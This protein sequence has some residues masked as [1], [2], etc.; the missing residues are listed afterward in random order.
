MT[1]FVNADNGDE[2][3]LVTFDKMSSTAHTW[4]EM[5]DPV[6]GGRSTGTT[7]VTNGMLIFDGEV[8]IV[9]SLQAP[10]FIT[11]TTRD[12]K[13]F[14]DV[15]ACQGVALTLKSEMPY[16]GYRFSFGSAHAPG[17]KFFAYGYKCHIDVPVGD[18]GTVQIPF[19][20]FTDYWD[21]A[22]GNPI[23]TCEEGKIYCPDESTLRNMKTMQ[24][25]GEGIAGKVHLEV[26]AISAYGCTTN[27]TTEPSFIVA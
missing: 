16:K 2:I 10:G 22:T 13:R 25:W 15:S 4:R 18:F 20:N 27:S 26:K 12:G 24:F 5:N 23:K 8:A 19:S 21:D 17:G 7:T 3:A 9:P 14:P 1:R 6:M 11:S